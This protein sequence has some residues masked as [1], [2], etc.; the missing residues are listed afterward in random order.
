MAVFAALTAGARLVLADD[1]LVRDPLSL[2]DVLRRS[3]ATFMQ[4]SPTTWRMLVESGWSAPAGFRALAGGE[5]STADLLRRLGST[6]AEVWDMYGPTETTVFSFGTRH[7]EPAGEATLVAGNTTVHLLDDRLDPVLPGVDGQV[8]VGGDGLARGYLGQPRSTADAFVPDP[9]AAAPGARMYATGDVGRRDAVGRIEILGRCDTQLK[10]RGLRV[11]LG[12]IENVL[13]TNPGVRAAVVHPVGD[14]TGEPRLAA[15]VVV[16]HGEVTVAD[17]RRHL[18]GRLPAHMV[19]THVVVLDSFPRLANGKVDRAALPVP[20]RERP[21]VTTYAPPV[22]QTEQAIAAVWA[23]ALGVDRVGREDDFY[24]L[25]GHSL[26]TMR[27]I[28]RL[29]REHGLDVTFRDVLT[30]R[31]VRG[32]AAAVAAAGAVGA[33]ARA[34]ALLWLGARGTATPLFC[35]HPGGGSAHWYRDL[36]DA[37][38]PDRPLAAFEWPGLHREQAVPGSIAGIAA[39]YVRE[40]R[41]ARPAGPYH[42]LG[43]CGSSG[44]AWEMARHLRA[45]GH[46]VGLILIDPFEYPTARVNPILANLEVVRRAER[47]I[48]TLRD[49]PTEG[50][51]QVRAERLEILRDLVDDGDLPV[52]PDD[53]AHD[54]AWTHRLRTWREMLALRSGYRFPRYTGPV[55]LVVCEALA[56]GGYADLIGL[57]F[58]QYVDKWR[59]LAAG[60]VRVHS[61][62]GDHRSALE[63]PHVSVLAATLADII[64]RTGG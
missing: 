30:G 46:R 23:D 43:W 47:L 45:D 57:E 18:D 58:N 59:G 62:P 21:D 27:I 9:Y 25:G 24:A 22:G 38:A 4:A 42:I 19:P 64:D 40:L 17:L 28:A 20:G 8:F 44:I 10:I 2:A 26:L 1:D 13:A 35:V 12:E 48:A 16:A 15:Y 50:R 11:E 60:G 33:D 61:A 29:R 51:A 14:S 49:T 34:S 53:L 6:G 56:T 39:E 54:D 32:V 55:D 41:T 37:F 63:P 7:R 5:A 52:D 3:G 31:T 36:A